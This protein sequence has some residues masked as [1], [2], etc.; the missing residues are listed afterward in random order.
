MKTVVLTAAVLG[1]VCGVLRVQ[2]SSAI[3]FGEL[4]VDRDDTLSLTE[5]GSVL[6]DITSRW[7]DL[8]TD[9]DGKLNR[10]EYAAYI[11]PP[12]AAGRQD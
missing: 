4:D 2:A 1:A 11:F 12:S 5:A 7:Y 6:P 10:G 3:P 8:D 9:G